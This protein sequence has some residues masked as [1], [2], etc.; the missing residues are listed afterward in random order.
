MPL[1]LAP[2]QVIADQSSIRQGLDPPSQMVTMTGQQGS[3]AADVPPWDTRRR[4]VML[5]CGIPFPV[6]MGISGDVV[7]TN[8]DKEPVE[9]QE[10]RVTGVKRR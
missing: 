7:H 1:D 9:T 5:G 4:S 2:E 10:G 3:K 6:Y 8:T